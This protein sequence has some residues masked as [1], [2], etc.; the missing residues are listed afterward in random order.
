[1]I[2][3]KHPKRI[4]ARADVDPQ[5]TANPRLTGAWKSWEIKATAPPAAADYEKT[6]I[7]TTTKV[8]VSPSRGAFAWAVMDEGVKV[9]INTPYVDEATTPGMKTAWLGTGERD[10]FNM[11][12]VIF[13]FLQGD[14]WRTANESTLRF[15]PGIRYLIIAYVDHDSGR[16]RVSP[17]QDLARS[18]PEGP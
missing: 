18:A 2:H 8:T 13:E 4:T 10:P 9:R 11:A 16:P 14:Q 17:L 15:L 5:N 3:E 1:L 12:P 7:V 6:D